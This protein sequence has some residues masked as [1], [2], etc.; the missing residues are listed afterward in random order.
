MVSH[1]KSS[2]NCG[3]YSCHEIVEC[4]SKYRTSNRGVIVM[5]TWDLQETRK[6]VERIYGRDQLQLIAPCL[7]SVADR[8][9]Y[10]YV[11]Y[12]DFRKLLEDYLKSNAEHLPE[13]FLYWTSLDGGQEEFDEFI[14]RVGAQV[15]ACVQ[16]LHSIPDI[17]AHVIYF[18]IGLNLD[19]S[20]DAHKVNVGSVSQ[21][22]Q[23][24]PGAVEL[25]RILNSFKDGGAHLSALAN[26]AKH[27]SVVLPSFSEDWTGQRA[28]RHTI[29]IQRFEH[30]GVAYPE[31]MAK[32]FLQ[33]EFDRTTKL[34][35]QAGIQLNMLLCDR[36]N[37]IQTDPGAPSAL[38]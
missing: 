36:L 29:L 33:N 12:Q 16:S 24:I 21:K 26:R 32:S 30:D 28:E 2:S 23:L 1:A 31:V 10:A 6:T 3:M 13:T 22:L 4:S 8:Q 20:I 37:K 19:N 14:L 34:F 11:H 25:R 27:R 18:A 35:V 15:T 38:L 7:R 9:G 17:L 5:T